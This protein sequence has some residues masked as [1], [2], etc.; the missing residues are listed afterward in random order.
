VQ[1]VQP[2]V[3]RRASQPHAFALV[4][5]FQSVVRQVVVEAAYRDVGEQR[6]PD[7]C[8]DDR[9]FGR[10]SLRDPTLRLHIGHDVTL[11]PR[12]LDRF[13]S[14]VGL[15]AKLRANHRD[16]EQCS[17]APLGG[18]HA[19]FADA[20]EGVEAQ[21]LHFLGQALDRD[22]MDDLFARSAPTG[23]LAWWAM[24]LRVVGTVAVFAVGVA[25]VAISGVAFC[26]G[27]GVLLGCCQQLLC[28]L[29]CV[30]AFDVRAS[31]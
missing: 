5:V 20:L 13:D 22:L 23:R 16:L 10:W 8:A 12:Q 31:Q 21:S 3:Q 28:E 1:R 29:L 2:A 9:Q 11:G 6:R 27:F 30:L 24:G 14:R 15:R 25:A 26:A 7:A 19:I 17:D 4:D 18:A